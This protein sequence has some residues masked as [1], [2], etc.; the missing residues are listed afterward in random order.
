VRAKAWTIPAARM[1]GK[2]GKARP[3]VVPLTDRMISIIEALPANGTKYLFAVGRRPYDLDDKDKANLDRRM[4]RTLR[5][6]ARREEP[7][8]VDLPPWVNQ[9]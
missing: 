9:I 5:A 4:L 8:A 6:L 7:N 2:N 3:H 1:K